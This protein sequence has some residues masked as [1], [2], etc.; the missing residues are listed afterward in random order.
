MQTYIPRPE[1]VEGPVG[2]EGSPMSRRDVLRSEPSVFGAAL[3]P[4]VGIIHTSTAVSALLALQA[5]EDAD[6]NTLLNIEDVLVFAIF[7]RALLLLAVAVQIQNV[8]LVSYDQNLW[9]VLG[10][11]T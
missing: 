5:N 9:M 10:G 6:G 2:S 4:E 8:N 1:Q 3:A 11:V 7:R